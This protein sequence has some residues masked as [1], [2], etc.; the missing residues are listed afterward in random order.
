MSSGTCAYTPP[1]PPTK[2]SE[3]SQSALRGALPSTATPLPPSTSENIAIA[4]GSGPRRD[5][6]QGDQPIKSTPPTSADQAPQIRYCYFISA[7][8]AAN[9]IS[10]NPSLTRN[11]VYLTPLTQGQMDNS[12]NG[13]QPRSRSDATSSSLF[14]LGPHPPQIQLQFLEHEPLPPPSSTLNIALETAEEI[15]SEEVHRHSSD[16][17]MVER[18]DSGYGGSVSRSSSLAAFG[19]GIRKVF[20]KTSAKGSI[21]SV[22]ITDPPVLD[23]GIPQDVLDH[24]SWAQDLAQRLSLASGPD[25]VTAWL[26]QLTAEG[27]EAGIALV[28]ETVN[29]A[30]GD[31]DNINGTL[32]S[33]TMMNV[34]EGSASSESMLDMIEE[35]FF[36][37]PASVPTT[38]APAPVSVPTPSPMSSVVELANISKPLPPTKSFTV[39]AP[40][41][42]SLRHVLSTEQ[43][44]K[45]QPPIPTSS[46]VKPAMNQA[47]RS[48]GST[49][50][51]NSI[52]KRFTV[53]DFGFRKASIGKQADAAKTRGEIAHDLFHGNSAAAASTP[54][55]RTTA[56]LVRDVNNVPLMNSPDELEGASYLSIKP[57]SKRSNRFFKS[58]T[59]SVANEMKNSRQ[60]EVR[61]LSEVLLSHSNLSPEEISAEIVTASRSSS[62]RSPPMRRSA[63]PQWEQSSPA[64]SA[65]PTLRTSHL[66]VNSV[67]SPPEPLFYNK[68]RAASASSLDTSSCG[69]VESGDDWDS[70]T[71][72]MINHSQ[73]QNARY[74]EDLKGLQALLFQPLEQSAP[75]RPVSFL[76]HSTNTSTGSLALP[77]ASSSPGSR[78]TTVHLKL[79]SKKDDYMSHRLSGISSKVLPVTGKSKPKKSRLSMTYGGGELEVVKSAKFDTPEAV[80]RN[81]EIRK[82]ISQEIFTTEQ[83]YLQ[84]LHTVQEVFVDPLF[85]SLQTDKPFIPK[86]NALYHLLSH[87]AGLIDVSSQLTQSLE[88]CVRDEVWSDDSTLIGTIFL[89]VKEPLSIFLKYGQAYGKGMKALRTL[90]KSKRSSISVMPSPSPFFVP[91]S[92]LSSCSS[93]GSNHLAVPGVGEPAPR[94]GKRRS[95]PSLFSLNSSSAPASSSMMAFAAAAAASTSSASSAAHAQTRRLSTASSN[96]TSSVSRALSSHGSIHPSVISS[97]STTMPAEPSEFQRF[98][99]NCAGGKEMTGRFSLADLLI[100]PIQRVTRYCLL[101]KDLKRHTHTDH[102]DYVGLVH[103]LE[104]LH[105]LA[106][107]TN[108]VQPMSMRL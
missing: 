84:Y 25:A 51:F 20:W 28:E 53:A 99:Q 49:S 95:L 33:A 30:N 85:R 100:L 18:K 11:S 44:N 63:L 10:R 35:V 22:V 19:R 42:K 75:S 47:S 58:L 87:I 80:A 96:S 88:D 6:C 45:P 13:T 40:P 94:L 60:N 16:A 21:E 73:A 76:S 102:E 14:L 55:L 34:P 64:V 66:S 105:T 92:T 86:S 36:T 79:T 90:M 57:A 54:S 12:P 107:A 32:I 71:Q 5:S 104:Q 23:Y 8:S 65:V 89:N 26:G 67:L 77:S 69:S 43:L 81:K 38:S 29:V 61:P 68:G 39:P 46:P 83:N 74:N 3:H 106:M 52:A 24:E 101:L 70:L 1:P 4:Q 2:P 108:N 93:A 72:T 56:G 62:L 41:A 37:L 27:S 103:A 15:D 31:N 48:N 82:F 17:V 50:P 78:D 91:A 9:S 97:T 7:A 98:L 59:T